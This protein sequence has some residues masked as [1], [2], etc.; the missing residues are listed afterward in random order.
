M[1]KLLEKA[2]ITYLR[3]FAH[4][5]LKKN[6][7]A[8]V[9]GITGSAGKTSAK[10]ATYSAIKDFAKTKLCEH[11]NSETG[12]PLDILG[13]KVKDY[14]MID[15]LRLAFLGI[16]KLLTN[17][18]KFDVIIIEMAIDSP[19]YPKN[20]DHLLSIVQ[21][22]I[23]VFLNVSSVHGANYEPKL[24]QDESPNEQNIKRLIAKEKAKMINSLPKTGTA[25]LNKDDPLVME[26]SVKTEAKVFTFGSNADFSMADAKFSLE[27]GSEFTITNRNER[28][29]LSFVDN[30]LGQAYGYSFLSAVAVATALGI[31]FVQSAKALEKNFK[32][33]PSRMS[34]LKGINNSW[35]ID[36]SY[37]ASALSTEELIKTCSSV[38]AKKKVAV[39]GDMRETG[40]AGTEIHL[41][42]AKLAVSVFDE[43]IFVGKIFGSISDDL[44]RSAPENRSKTQFFERAGQAV[45]SATNLAEEGTLF[46]V[47]GSQN[48]I[49]LEIV[50]EALLADPIDLDLVCRQDPYWKQKGY[51]FAQK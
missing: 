44:L 51:P 21:P 6:P 25:I 22:D 29:T 46:A 30:V 23:G 39:L 28:T 35:I 10:L 26:Y 19:F 27:N 4:L 1:R 49:F 32:L 20:M 31:P 14:S 47:K 16:W 12:I 13:L 18:D 38:K 33:P 5:Q 7:N 24:R 45:D 3:S 17:W 11:G 15:W 36:S 43:V 34:L 2:F 9:I 48:E 50:V 42:I 41:R 37:N 40:K 8:K